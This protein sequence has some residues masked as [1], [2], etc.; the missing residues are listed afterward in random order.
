MLTFINGACAHYIMLSK[1]QWKPFWLATQQY[2][3]NDWLG[4]KIVWAMTYWHRPHWSV[5]IGGGCH[6]CC[7]SSSF[8]KSSLEKRNVANSMKV[9]KLSKITQVWKLSWC[10]VHSLHLQSFLNQ[11]PTRFPRPKAPQIISNVSSVS[12]YRSHCDGFVFVLH[13]DLVVQSI[14]QRKCPRRNGGRHV[15]NVWSQ[16]GRHSHVRS[17]RQPVRKIPTAGEHACY[18]LLTK[19][20]VNAEI[21]S[22]LWRSLM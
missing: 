3:E 15:H 9:T 4:G 14:H 1:I 21:V 13:A 11:N 18:Q 6:E 8:E 19:L 2:P 22:F 7:Q 5:S 20:W 17:S 16:H 10:L 12:L